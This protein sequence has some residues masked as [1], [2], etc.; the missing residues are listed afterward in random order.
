MAPI[1]FLWLVLGS[2]AAPGA[3]CDQSAWAHVYHGARFTSGISARADDNP[4][5]LVLKACVTVTGT[6][7]TSLT[8]KDGDLHIRMAVDPQFRSMLNARNISGQRGDLVVEPVCQGK[9]TQ[10]DTLKEKACE[11][12]AGLKFD[13]ALLGKRVTVTGPLVTDR[14]HGWNELHPPSVIDAAH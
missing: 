14:E 13:R 1:L 10:A 9:V 11:G 6:L 3:P 4:R 5:L 7:E 12:Y 8:E 2:H